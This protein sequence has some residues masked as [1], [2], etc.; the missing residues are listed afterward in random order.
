M[1]EVGMPLLEMLAI[2]YKAPEAMYGSPD[3]LPPPIFLYLIPGV[4]L[5]RIHREIRTTIILI[6]PK[7]YLSRNSI[8]QECLNGLRFTEQT[9][10]KT[11]MLLHAIKLIY[12]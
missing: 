10:S 3:L 6:L 12:L 8:L 11:A 7:I 4:D 1:V 2:G 5:T 9:W